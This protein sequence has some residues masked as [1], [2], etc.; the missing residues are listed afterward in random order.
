MATANHR[1]AAQGNPLAGLIRT[2]WFEVSV[3]RKVSKKGGCDTQFEGS[4]VND[5]FAGEISDY[6]E[7]CHQ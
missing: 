4:R 2:G 3:V 5:G 7:G 1:S 6:S